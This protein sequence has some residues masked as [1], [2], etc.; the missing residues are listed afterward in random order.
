MSYESSLLNISKISPLFQIQPPLG[1]SRFS[2]PLTLASDLIPLKFIF[3]S[4][5][6][7][8]HRKSKFNVSFPT[9]ESFGAFLFSTNKFPNPWADPY[10]SEDMAPD[11]PA[12]TRS[13]L[14]VNDSWSILYGT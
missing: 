12:S 9:E 5:T 4:A 8:I 7:V 3:H 10:I 11:Y 1:K 6:R 14:H 13:Y 2:L